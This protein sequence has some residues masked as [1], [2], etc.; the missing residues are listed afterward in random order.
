MV[1]HVHTLPKFWIFLYCEQMY[2][3]YNVNGALK[4]RIDVGSH[5]RCM[6]F[7]QSKARSLK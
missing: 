6:D 3:Y 7:V 4:Q 5:L 1:L 2:D